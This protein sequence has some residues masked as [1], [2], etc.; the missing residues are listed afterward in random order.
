MGPLSLA[1][2]AYPVFR[3]LGNSGALTGT[4]FRLPK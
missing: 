2:L 1:R 4:G 3:A